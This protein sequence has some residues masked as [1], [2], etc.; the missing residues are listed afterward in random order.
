MTGLSSK[1]TT[2]TRWPTVSPRSSIARGAPT[3]MASLTHTRAVGGSAEAISSSA[4]V[5]RNHAIFSPPDQA[6]GG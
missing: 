6:R 2:E 5:G 1:P 3:A 4:N